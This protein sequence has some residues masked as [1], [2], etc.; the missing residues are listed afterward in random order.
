MLRWRAAASLRR[1]AL[2]RAAELVQ[3]TQLLTQPIG[4]VICS[5]TTAAGKARLKK[6]ANRAAWLQRVT[7]TPRPAKKPFSEYTP[8]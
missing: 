1:D 8:E 6:A 2:L 5:M 3:Q 7:Q 4:R